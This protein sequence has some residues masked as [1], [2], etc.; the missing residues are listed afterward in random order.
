MRNIRYKELLAAWQKKVGAIP[1]AISTS[2]GA[3][4]RGPGGMPIA[5]DVMGDKLEMILKAVDALKKEIA[6]KKGTFDI[7]DDFRRGKR[8]FDITLKPAAA[9]Y[10]IT[11]IDAARQIQ[12][13][14]YG[15]EALRI[16]SGK[17]DVKVK[18]KYPIRS[19]RDSIE[20]FKKMR[21]RDSAGNMIP[22]LTVVKVSLA[23]GESIIRRKDRMRKVA[24]RSDVDKLKGNA[25]DIIEELERKFLP[26]LEKRYGVTCDVTGQQEQT[27]D[28]LG[29][30]FF[31]FPIAL[32][33]IYFVIASMFKS[34]IQPMVIMTTIPFGMMGAIIGHIIFGKD[35]AIFSLFGMVALAGIVV[36]DA[37]VF[38]ECANNRLE[39]GETLMTA[40]REAGKRRFRA[41]MLTTMTTFAGLMP[42][43]FEKSMQ[44][45]YLKPM[46]ISIAFGVLFATIITLV[47]IPCLMVVLNDIRRFAHYLLRGEWPSREQV[48]HRAPT[49]NKHTA[50]R[51]QK[52]RI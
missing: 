25:N 48:E 16:Q 49:E 9:K 31:F 41:I 5:V 44:A 13:A 45:A 20:A 10:G 21:I 3:M 6:E 7:T 17:D 22:V 34:Y 14:F 40:L 32:F 23:Q 12:S 2:F 50:N 1:G 26:E 24:V 52:S 4:K 37:I 39:V 36:N 46:A 33:G 35:L 51:K 15:G 19:G 27:R 42:I 18:V 47:L 8:E 28:S 30:L 43:I 29:A 38:I 11:L